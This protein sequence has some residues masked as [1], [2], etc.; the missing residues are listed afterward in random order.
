MLVTAGTLAGLWATAAPVLAQDAPRRHALVIGVNRY[1]AEIEGVNALKYAEDDAKAVADI[2]KDQYE[3]VALLRDLA[4]RETI[5]EQFARLAREVKPQD[6]VLIYFAGHGVTATLG[7]KTLSYWLVY[8]TTL[9]RLEVDGLRL[10]HILDYVDDIPAKKKLIILDHCHSG[11]VDFVTAGGAGGRRSGA[12]SL[13]VTR[14]LFSAGEFQ[15]NVTGRVRQGLVILGAADRDAYELDTLKHGVFTYALIQALT[16]SAADTNRDG[17][18]SVDELRTQI[19]DKVKEL[20]NRAQLEQEPIEVL[21]GTTQGWNVLTLPREGEVE[22]RQLRDVIRQL[23][24]RGNLDFQVNNAVTLA[25]NN[26]GQARRSGVPPNARDDSIVAE[27]RSIQTLGDS[28]D[29]PTKAG[30][31]V[32]FMQRLNQ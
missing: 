22:V 19:V 7:D 17:I 15:G 2:L 21:L 32:S 23:E 1:L 11:N 29:W 12:G 25:V 26:W 4:R 28:V 9:A 13:R 16:T 30:R 31:L 24:D 27:L 20:L 18:L 14:N 6:S 8:P 5:V 10:Q 3:T